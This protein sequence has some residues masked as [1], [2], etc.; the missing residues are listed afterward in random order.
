MSPTPRTRSGRARLSGFSPSVLLLAACLAPAALRAAPETPSVL[1]ITLDTTRADSVGPQLTPNLDRLARRGTRY[2]NAISPAPLT[3]PAHCS[4]LTGLAPPEH[5][6]R[7]NGVGALAPEFPTLA[8]V[9]A[10]RGYATG[11]FVSSRV[12]DHRFGLDRGFATYDDR[13]VA[14]QMGELGYPE[15]D[16]AAVTDAAL[17]WAG[18]LP[19]GRPYF[20]WIHYYDP[21]AAYR[22]PG[23]WAGKTK[24]QRYGGEVA[25]MDAQI[26]RLLSGLP[27]TEAG[28]LVAAVGDHGEMLGE[29]GEREHGIL[30]Y[31]G[32]L[33]VPLILAGPR[34]PAGAEVRDLVGTRALASTLLALLGAAEDA[35]PF[36]TGLPGVGLP[37]KSP[38][39][40]YSETF[41][42]ASSFGW[43]PMRSVTNRRF[44]YVEAPL[45]ELYD[46]AADPGESRN[47]VSKLPEETRRLRRIVQSV[48][49][50]T[51]ASPN[52]RADPELAASLRSLGY[53]SGSSPHREGGLDPKDGIEMLAE[54][55]EAKR[56]LRE[57]RRMEAVE[58]MERLVRRSPGNV[59]FLF[60]LGDAQMSVGLTDE[61]LRSLSFAVSLSPNLD[62]PLVRLAQ[63]Y[64]E[65]GRAAEATRA[66]R[67]A[68]RLNPRSAPAWSGLAEVARRTEGP[69]AE[70]KVLEECE[71]AGTRSASLLAR[72]SELELAMGNTALGRRHAEEAARWFASVRP[73][74]GKAE[75]D[76]TARPAST[77]RPHE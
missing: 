35:K 19:I 72:L 15:R 73:E 51:P 41:L 42:P 66:Y 37:G 56:W 70:R 26:G 32:S 44:R 69:A 71:S 55:D 58:K 39:T 38:E 30:L 21:H 24:A 34:V 65:V 77:P 36:G 9:L 12:L 11:A 7:D 2:S 47:L 5:G 57:G 68:L 50:R 4:L 63:A 8:S 64:A 29:H 6:I 18:K 3:L 54:F 45:P 13:M 52:V 61:G 75:E 14:E 43:S 76:D 25:F 62:F 40:V 33:S 17:S 60:R 28:R 31:R 67:A 59:P 10:E 27:E 46:L 53:L 49:T 22:P 1:L 16:G 20:L 23:D 48:E 74:A